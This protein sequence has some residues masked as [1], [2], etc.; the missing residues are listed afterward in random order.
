VELERYLFY[1]QRFANHHNAAKFASK[2]RETAAQVSTDYNRDGGDDAGDEGPG[3]LPLLRLANEER[4]AEG[5]RAREI[6]TRNGFR[7]TRQASQPR[8]ERDGLRV[9]ATL[10]VPP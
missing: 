2:M 10:S 1:Y 4:N 6:T 7:Q 9:A 8:E 3:E 5:H